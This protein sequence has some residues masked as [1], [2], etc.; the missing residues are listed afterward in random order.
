MN[1]PQSS[2]LIEQYATSAGLKT[3]NAK[4]R[5]IKHSRTRS[6]KFATIE[7]R[8][9]AAADATPEAVEAGKRASSLSE[10]AAD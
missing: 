10:T 4:N 7:A 3:A 6:K 8:K 5:F 9:V 1:A 2:N